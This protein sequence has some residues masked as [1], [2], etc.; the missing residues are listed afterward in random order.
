MPHRSKKMS[1]R[2]ISLSILVLLPTIICAHGSHGSGF[3]AGFTHPILG[4]DHNI[5]IL[6]C[7]FLGYAIDKKKFY[8]YPLAFILAMVLGGLSGIDNEATVKIEKVI[9]FS[10][11]F[12]GIIIAF[13][14][15]LNTYLILTLLI[16]FGGF[17][18]YAHGA[19]MSETNT[20]F[21]YISGYSLGA[22]L[23]AG[24]GALIGKIMNLSKFEETFTMMLSILIVGLGMILLLS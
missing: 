21:K 14:K 8:L 10:V 11:L 23:L 1:Q 16:I 9:A 18:G 15:K 17:H 4:L 22:V 13:R 12:I 5:A 24:F 7:A 19:E 2:I 3:M 20:A 6:S